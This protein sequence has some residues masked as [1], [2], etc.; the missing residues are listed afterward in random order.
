MNKLLAAFLCCGTLMTGV[1]HVHAAP[2]L[3]IASFAKKPKTQFLP[4]NQAFGIDSSVENGIL[5][6][7]MRVTPEHYLYKDKLKLKL[8]DGQVLDNL[9]FS[10][11][12]TTVDDPEFGQVAVFERDVVATIDLKG[13]SGAATLTWQGCAKAGLCYPPQKKA[14]DLGEATTTPVSANTNTNASDSANVKAQDSAKPNKEASAPVAQTTAKQENVAQVGQDNTAEESGTVEDFTAEQSVQE[15]DQA[16]NA[17]VEAKLVV[18][19]NGQVATATYD[20]NH[21]LT[22]TDPFGIAERPIFAVFLLFLAGLVLAF[23]PCIYPM[24]PIVASIVANGK[25]TAKRGFVLTA[26]YGLGVATSYGLLG[27]FAAWFGRELGILLWLQNPYVLI[28]FAL[29]FVLLALQM[30]GVVNLRLPAAL[31]NRLQQGAGRA[32]RFFGSVHGSFIAGT[33][34]ALVVSPCVSAPL[35]GALGAV[36]VSGN[37]AFGFL[38]L[39]CLGLGLSVPL[40]AVG[41]TQGRFMPKAGAWMVAVKQLGGLLLLAV[42]LLL[43][44]RVVV[45]SFM[46][47]VW[48][49]WF[50]ALAV[51]LWRLGKGWAK[52]VA[53]LAGV[54]A[55]CLVVGFALGAKNPWQP[56]HS[57]SSTNAAAAIKVTTLQEL[58][59]ILATTPNVLV[60]VTA[61]WCIECKIMDVNLF[62]DPPAELAPWQVVKVDISDST[63]DAQAVLVRYQLFGP[64]TLLYYQNGQLV[65]QQL[66]EVARADFVEQLT[67]L[68]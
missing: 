67:K 27:A 36:A 16:P 7:S 50:V 9:N 51:F 45:A 64:P 58:D 48:S 55:A 26:S 54:W 32:D 31:S 8:A 63:D 42:A 56:L 18:I 29:V 15:P 49:A 11:A 61:D 1:A 4:V 28:G 41:T 3:A 47:L 20:L 10:Q 25:P 35:A 38:A 68:N 62:Q 43:V 21:T 17:P 5:T 46:L 30:L 2:P 60:D 66:G 52:I 37:V 24:I 22:S 59:Q 57:T 39:F 53:L 23:T 44:N 6:L 34:S 12:P 19:P 14:I 13:A 40:V 33:L 65:A